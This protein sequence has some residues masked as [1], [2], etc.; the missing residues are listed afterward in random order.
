MSE[1][2]SRS[3]PRSIPFQPPQ[4]PLPPAPPARLWRWTLLLLGSTG[5]IAVALVVAGILTL[6][7]AGRRPEPPQPPPETA[8]GGARDPVPHPER[9]NPAAPLAEPVKSADTSRQTD[10]LLEALGGLTA[11]HLYQTYLNIGLLADNTESDVY[12][13]A[14]AKKLLET[15]TGLLDTVDRQLAKVAEQE[16]RPE[17]RKAL[18]RCRPLVVLL[19]TQAAELNAYWDTGDKEHTR[20]FH[21]AREEAWAGI[22][23]LLGFRE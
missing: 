18:A 10:R 5:V 20:K 14:E 9:N 17:D 21:Q 4:A 16:L 2:L 11:A 3:Y 23:E 7:H 15:L 13:I 12:T 22:R 8:G 19:G 6:Q 1:Q